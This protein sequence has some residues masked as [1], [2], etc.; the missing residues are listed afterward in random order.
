MLAK[1][2]VMLDASV[3]EI[4]GR[5]PDYDA[6]TF[7]SDTFRHTDM[8][9]HQSGDV[10]MMFTDNPETRT[11]EITL[12]TDEVPE[13]LTQHW[14]TGERFPVHIETEDFDLTV[15][16]AHVARLEDGLVTIVARVLRRGLA[17]G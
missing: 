1:E 3:V 2:P 5:S 11:Y 8:L 15:D 16:T 17:H 12:E 7:W 9:Q 10:Q 14:Q 6:L 4:D 13:Y